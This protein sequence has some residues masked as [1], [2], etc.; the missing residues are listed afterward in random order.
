[1]QISGIN[2][3][4]ATPANIPTP[5]IVLELNAIAYPHETPVP[6]YLIRSS[7]MV[8]GDIALGCLQ[9]RLKPFIEPWRRNAEI[10]EF[11]ERGAAI[12]KI[13]VG[14]YV[15]AECLTKKELSD[16]PSGGEAY[17]PPIFSYCGGWDQA[18]RTAAVI[19]WCPGRSD[20]N[21]DQHG[22]GLRRS[23]AAALAN[24]HLNH[25]D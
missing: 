23:R 18:L 3:K 10:A 7:L 19:I 4:V 25:F 12:A 11:T 14:I 13:L 8:C 1:M 15:G 20:A 5:I 24:S 16:L 6:L 22:D 2:T 21:A 17:R 9:H